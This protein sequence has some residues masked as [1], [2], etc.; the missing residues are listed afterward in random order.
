[1]VMDGEEELSKIVAVVM[2]LL[3]I[4]F[5][6]S[7]FLTYIDVAKLVSHVVQGDVE[8]S[9]EFREMIRGEIT[10]EVRWSITKEV[11][12]GVFGILS[13]LGVSGIGLLVALLRRL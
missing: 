5:L 13:C 8:A 6:A 4:A 10:S 12:I 2:S 3:I 7:D 11:L 1:M 9:Q